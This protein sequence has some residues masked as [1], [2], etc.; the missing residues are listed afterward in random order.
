MYYVLRI[1]NSRQRLFFAMV[2]V[3]LL[4]CFCPQAAMHIS[5]MTKNLIKQPIH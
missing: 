2:A 3:Q 1:D 5:Y 4:L